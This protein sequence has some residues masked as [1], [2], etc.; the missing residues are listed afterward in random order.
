MNHTQNLTEDSYRAILGE[1]ERMKSRSK[2]TQC[3][4]VLHLLLEHPQ[5]IWWWPWELVGQRTKSG[6]FLSY[7][8]PARASELANFE[9]HLVEDRSVGRF[10]VYRLRTENMNL[11]MKRLGLTNQKK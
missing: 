6:H 1:Y 2:G 10:K 5:K 9:S 8:A 7:K 11:I 4:G 3:E